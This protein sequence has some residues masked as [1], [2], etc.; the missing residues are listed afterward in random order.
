MNP[1]G[2]Y[3]SSARAGAAG[4]TLA[5]PGSRSG[6]PARSDI[7]RWMSTLDLCVVTP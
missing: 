5:E 7:M 2:S 1:S 4:G 3:A 6:A